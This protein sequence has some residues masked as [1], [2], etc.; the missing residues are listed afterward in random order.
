MEHRWGTR[1]SL[2]LGVRLDAGLPLPAFGWLRNAS[3]SGAYVETNFSPPP[4]SRI[5][6]ELESNTLGGDD[7]CRIPAY[8]VR[9]DGAGVGLEWCNF[10]PRAILALAEPDRRARAARRVPEPRS[11]APM[12]APRWAAHSQ[13]R[14]APE[15]PSASANH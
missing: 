6:I 4:W 7:F 11:E 2:E 12:Q 10:A 13:S 9:T 5:W 8:V 15:P 3:S 14:A 1:H